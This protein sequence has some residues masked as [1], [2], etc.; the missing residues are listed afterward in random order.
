[1]TVEPDILS[2]EFATDP[3]A[4]LEVMRE[5]YPVVYNEAMQSWMI[6][7]YDDVERAFKDKEFTSKNYEWQLEP[8]H[9]RTILQ[10][11]GRDHSLHRNLIAP[12][13]R[14]SELTAKFV[15]VIAQNAKELIDG[16]RDTGTVDLVDQFTIRFPINVIVDM[17]GL[18]KSDHERFQKWY[19]SIMEF[20]SNL[21]GDEEVM[22]AGLQTK[23]ELESYM[24]P[25]I[26]E[27]RANPGEDL[28]S[29]LCTAVIDG[30][31]M[32]DIEIKAFVSLLLVAGGETTDK[33]MANMMMNL[34]ANPDQL[35]AVRDD[36]SLV[37]NAFAETLRHS[38]PVQMIMRQPAE[39]VVFEGVTVPEGSTLTCLIA[40]ANRD[41]RHYSDPDTFNIFR[42]DLDASKAFSGAANHTGFALGRHFCIGAMLSKAEVEIATNQLL[43]AMDDIEFVG[44]PPTPVGV[45]TRAP[46][47]MPLAFTP[48]GR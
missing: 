47:T 16:F 41:P 11:E 15:P 48:T 8:V 45:F 18:D 35:Q 30:E 29:T 4:V 26:A 6:S 37:E 28:L 1:M 5:E 12:A 44:G 40:G 32:T 33:A 36:R 3:N 39:D 24:L 38:P 23:E 10:M 25:I 13:F 43:D 2:P 17:L 46:Q 22:A 19:H 27:R 21:S 31:Q 34:I 42:D 20:L 14:G 9:G 7:R